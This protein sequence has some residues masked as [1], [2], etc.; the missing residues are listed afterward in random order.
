MLDEVLAS[1]PRFPGIDFHS[2]YALALLLLLPG[3]WW[4]R[5]KRPAGAITY[6]G[7]ALLATLPHAGRGVTR[8]LIILRGL[9][10]AG[11]VV[12]LARPRAA[13]RAAQSNAEGINIVIAF[14]ISSSML[15]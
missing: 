11:L 15:A 8:A 13:G 10:I 7:T 5:R 1:L 6:S 14:D 2:P 3:W 4:W 12:A 9:A